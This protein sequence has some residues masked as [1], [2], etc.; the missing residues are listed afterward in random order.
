MSTQSELAEL[1]RR[2]LYPNYRQA[3]LAI[4]RGE[5]ALLWDADGK[6]YV[7]M[8]GGIAVSSLGHAHPKL[9]AAIADQ[10]A[11][12]I[13]VSNYYYNEPNV[14]LAQ[15]L[16]TLTGMARAFFCNSGTEAVEAALKLS[17][18]HFHTLGQPERLKVLA[19]TNSFHGRTLGALAAT[20]QEKY[21][22]G[23]GPLPGALHV[24]YGDLE[25]T[26]RALGPE[27]AAV[28]FEPV[29]GEGGVVPPPPG[30]IR[31]LRALTEQTG[32]LLIADEIQTGVGRTGTFLACEQAG[33]R[34]DLVVLA[35]GL[36]G[37]VPIGALLCTEALTEA[38]PPGAHGSTFGGNPLASRAAL[39]VLETLESE[40]LLSR[41]RELGGVLASG[42]EKLV[43]RH[44]KKLE[45]ARGSGLLQAAVLV[46]GIEP[47]TVLGTLQERGLLSSVAGARAL[48][49]SP[50]LVVTQE[51]I[52][53]ALGI[54]DATLGELTV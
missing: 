50:P 39:T 53:E 32:T 20:G 12:V 38:L 13:Q 35:K 46:E 3:P 40:N 48:R 26:R 23:F 21:K 27:V 15:K 37:G 19:Y 5:G 47:R 42:L 8:L 54:L 33:V 29:Q 10:A 22:Q 7:D 1:G 18:R 49:F 25:A 31:E 34:P 36:A 43:V 30:F 6:R 4:V 2:Y 45:G 51:Q 41:T 28:I 17:R 44:P 16:C 9:V 11:R 52:A 14:R 24:P